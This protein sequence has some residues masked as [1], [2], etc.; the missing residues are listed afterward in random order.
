MSCVLATHR[1]QLPGRVTPIVT[2]AINQILSPPGLRSR[3][4]S[5]I[6][7]ARTLSF[8]GEHHFSTFSRRTR[9]L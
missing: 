5:T 6:L 7:L 2:N 9:D 8:S 3:A 4:P 1:N